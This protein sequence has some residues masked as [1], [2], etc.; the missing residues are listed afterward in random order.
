V[1][2]IS[3]ESDNAFQLYGNFYALPKRRGK[4]ETKPIFE[5]LYLGNA[6]HDFGMW[7]TDGEGHLHSKNHPVSY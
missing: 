3:R 2:H 5:S 4:K 1:Y 7:G 6:W